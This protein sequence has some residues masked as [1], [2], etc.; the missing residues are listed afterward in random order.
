MKQQVN[1]YLPELRRQKDW[2][3]FQG[4]L[5]S[6]AGLAIVLVLVSGF[7]AWQLYRLDGELQVADAERESMLEQINAM[8]A[9]MSATT[10]D[11]ELARMVSTMER[12]LEARRAVLD[13]MENSAEGNTQG[14]SSYMAD[15]SRAHLEGLRLSG[16]ELVDSGNNVSLSGE[17]SRADI[18]PLFLQ[19]LGDQGSFRGKSFESVSIGSEQDRLLFRLATSA[20]DRQTAGSR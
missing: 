2:L 3:D 4:L 13:F 18:V 9:R 6:V 8:V 7:Q 5:K 10:A 19:R 17:I 12:E 16:F 15:L 1:L 14:F 11:P 20:A